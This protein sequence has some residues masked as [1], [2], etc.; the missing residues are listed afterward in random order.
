MQSHQGAFRESQLQQ[1][2]ARIDAAS[3]RMT[4]SIRSV[5]DCLHNREQLGQNGPLVPVAAWR[6]VNSGAFPPKFP[7]NLEALFLWTGE[8]VEEVL[9]FY[10][11]DLPAGATV[12]DKKLRLIKT[13][14][15]RV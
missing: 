14:T 11:V 1:L 13:I 5:S 2:R 10:A 15:L 7:E 3:I 12:V 4:N 9:K 6:G 8:Q